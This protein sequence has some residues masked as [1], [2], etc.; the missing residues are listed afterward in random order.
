MELDLG[1]LLAD[2]RW[3][4]RIFN[5][6]WVGS[7][8]GERAV[9]EP[10]TG[11][12]F[13]KTG[14]ANAADITAA[15]AA[16]AAAQPAWAAFDA[17]QRAAIFRKAAA[18]LEQDGQALGTLVAR[19]SGGIIPKGLHEIRET[20]QILF[21]AAALATAPRGEVLANPPGRLS[22]A[23]RV[24]RG[25]VGVISPFNFP[26]ILSMRAV[27]PA[28]A[29]GNTVVLKSDPQTPFGGGIIIA[30]VLEEAG[31]PP[32][33]LHV[34]PGAAEAGEALCLDRNVAM[35][36]FTGSTA[37]GRRVGELAG[38]T[39][40]KVSLELGGNNALIVLD[41]ADLDKAVNNAAWGAFMHQGQICMAS[42][43]IFVQAGIADEFVKRLAAKAAH[44]PAGDPA[45]G[46]VALG[47]V[48]SERQLQRVKRILGE[49][50]QAGAT[51]AAGGGSTALFHEAT[52][53]T[54]VKPGMPAFDEETFGPVANVIT[55][56]TDE[57]ALELANR[58]EGALAAAVISRDVGRAM[59]ITDRLKAGM[60]H[61]NDQT[62]NDDAN[63]PFGGPGV[64]GAGSSV[65]GPAD[66]DEYT[67]WQ[68]ITVKDTPPTYPF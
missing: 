31:L 54:G 58:H 20:A 5:G 48:I 22:Y 10:A 63:N 27:A 52:V 21:N 3:E 59:R 16:A 2:R 19:E 67:T 49:S 33:T 55:F 25:V 11:R 7:L 9:P 66:L 68:W 30:R 37:V 64:A 60:V 43:R 50:V 61:I 6:Q 1:S 35:I 29:T 42:S 53:L 18:I 57:E 32:G 26:L 40:K 13:P 39:L 4:G 47:P 36:Q 8:G 15:C 41:D 62:V 51:I 23:R 12:P 17:R 34:V 38:R 56:G 44:L 24:A 14:F 28:L 45:T 46:Q 65:G